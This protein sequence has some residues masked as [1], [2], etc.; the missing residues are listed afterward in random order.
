M[1]FSSFSVLQ[2]LFSLFSFSKNVFAIFVFGKFIFSFSFS[3]IIL[4]KQSP[5][6]LPNEP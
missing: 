1:M 2:S 3:E 4:R 5:K 6:T